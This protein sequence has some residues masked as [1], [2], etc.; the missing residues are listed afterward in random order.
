VALLD[1]SGEDTV[2]CMTTDAT[3]GHKPPSGAQPNDSPFCLMAH[4]LQIETP[5]EV[6]A[7]G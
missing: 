3:G 1:Q 7:F 5:L 4:N 2:G 6:T